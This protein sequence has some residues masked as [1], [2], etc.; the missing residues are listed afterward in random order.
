LKKTKKEKQT[1]KLEVTGAEQVWPGK[2]NE[3]GARKEVRKVRG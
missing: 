3:D 1:A 2:Y